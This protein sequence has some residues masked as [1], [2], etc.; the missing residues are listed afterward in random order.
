LIETY[1]FYTEN[2]QIGKF[3]YTFQTDFGVL[4]Y[5]EF[6]QS[7]YLFSEDKLSTI[8]PYEISFFP[9]NRKKR[10]FDLKIRNTIIKL[11]QYFIDKNDCSIF[12]ICDSSDKREYKRLRL[13]IKWYSVCENINYVHDYRII[14]FED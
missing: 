1:P 5:V 2:E 6:F 11:I 3:V 14:E 9:K 13:F 10:I 12:Y 7:N 8:N 4:Y